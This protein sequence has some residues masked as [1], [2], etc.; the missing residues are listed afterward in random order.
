MEAL[1]CGVGLNRRHPCWPA[2]R[3]IGIRSPAEC[4][5]SG[6]VRAALWRLSDAGNSRM[7]T[8]L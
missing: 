4:H 1:Y 6:V 5:G 2:H 3:E 8:F 7:A